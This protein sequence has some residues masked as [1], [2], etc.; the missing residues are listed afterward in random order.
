MPPTLL[1]SDVSSG[2]PTSAA[3]FNNLRADALRFGAAAADAVAAAILLQRYDSG[4]SLQL[5]GSNRIR[6]PAL[7]TAVVCIVVD[8]YPLFAN[9]NVDLPS[10][11]APSGSANTYYLFA[12]HSAGSQTFTL[13]CNTS[14]AESTNRRMIGHFYWDGS[15]IIQNS[16]MTADRDYI[17]AQLNQGQ[18]DLCQGRI[19]LQSGL[20]VNPAD[21]WGGTVYYT[22]FTGNS[23]GLYV[24]GAGW[25]V[26]NFPEISI[27][28][29]GVAT[30]KNVDIF[31]YDNLGV[32]TL[33]M[34]VWASDNARSAAL[35]QQDG[36]W[37]L[38]TS[39]DRR[40]VGT[41]RTSS[42]ATAEDSQLRRF[43]WNYKNRV[44]RKLYVTDATA[45]WTYTLQT[46]HQANAN[47]ANLV[48]VVTGIQE[49]LLSLKCQ[50]VGMNA[51]SAVNAG[52][53]IGE[54]SV[55]ASIADFHNSLKASGSYQGTFTADLLRSPTIGYHAYNWLERAMPTGTTTWYTQ[56]TD[57]WPLG[58]G[59][60]G[61][62]DA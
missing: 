43:V 49:S 61:T 34:A 8:G 2:Q 47:V 36:I 50:C 60:L 13:D 58:S 19:T 14:S 51:S 52:V 20:P 25:R 16:I 30:G 59:L 32:V 53:G 26:Y 55:I 10:G 33:D 35:A 39:H 42:A 45:N 11:S 17:A 38:G 3:Q 5:L 37:V 48:Q 7:P 12:V 4:V 31:V 9:A 57:G 40:Y 41:I 27:S 46:F 56:S 15:K 23:I 44:Q 62:I 29:G 22:P 28:L 54:D 6:V 21:Y 24:L 18:A 1:S